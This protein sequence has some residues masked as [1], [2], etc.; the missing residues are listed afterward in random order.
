MLV[1]SRD[2]SYYNKLYL[3]LILLFKSAHVCSQ[4]FAADVLYVRK[5]YSINC[6]NKETNLGIMHFYTSE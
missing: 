5:G 4:S 6:R 3:I 1:F 2:G